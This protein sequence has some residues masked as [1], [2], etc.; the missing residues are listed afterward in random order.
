MS[1]FAH[2]TDPALAR[3]KTDAETADKRTR[4]RLTALE[5]RC[6]ALETFEA[7]VRDELYPWAVDLEAF[8]AFGT[9]PP[10]PPP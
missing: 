3:L 6:A 10:E 9:P 4:D 5:A 7:Y 2:Q 8:V 1:G